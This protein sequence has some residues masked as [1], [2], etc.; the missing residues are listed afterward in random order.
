MTTETSSDEAVIYA[1]AV[2][3][4]GQVALFRDRARAEQAARDLRGILVP[5]YKFVRVVP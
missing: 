2:E 1:W 4:S 3:Y 5:L